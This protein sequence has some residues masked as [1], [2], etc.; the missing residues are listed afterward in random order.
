[1]LKFRSSKKLAMLRPIR[2]PRLSWTRFCSSL[3]SFPEFNL[4]LLPVVIGGLAGWWGF[5][6]IPNLHDYGAEIGDV[7]QFICATFLL[8]LAWQ[9]ALG[10][11]RHRRLICFSTLVAWYVGAAFNFPIG[12]IQFWGDTCWSMPSWLY[13]PLISSLTWWG[14]VV[15]A[16]LLA[17]PVLFLPERILPWGLLIAVGLTAFTPVGVLSPLLTASVFIPGGGWVSIAFGGCL[18]A[19]TALTSAVWDWQV[20]QGDEPVHPFD[21]LLLLLTITCTI[22]IVLN[23]KYAPLISPFSLSSVAPLSFTDGKHDEQLLRRFQRQKRVADRSRDLITKTSSPLVVIT[24]E[25]TSGA[26]DAIEQIAWYPVAV[27]A[28]QKNSTVLAGVYREHPSYP[29]GANWQNGLL[30]IVSGDFYSATFS[31]PFGMFNPFGEKHFPNSLKNLTASIPTVHGSAAYLI[32]YEELLMLPLASKMTSGETTPTFLVSVANQWFM[33]QG[34]SSVQSRSVRM[35][36]R[37]WRLP[38]VRS[39]NFAI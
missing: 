17:C 33:R 5:V 27:T 35:Q 23:V 8:L 19:S 7:L 13:Q 29:G 20:E 30:D 21:V 38:L 12:V 34:D 24:P 18:L 28:K 1:M 9:L 26:W 31:V 22:G 32:C 6:D 36:A 16:F 39:Q 25:G 4:L 2:S 14:M 37:L 11:S 3:E 15:W 10:V